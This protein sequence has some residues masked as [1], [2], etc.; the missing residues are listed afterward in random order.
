M[1]NKFQVPVVGGVRKV[2]NLKTIVDQITNIQQQLSNVVNA[3]NTI[4]TVQTAQAASPATNTATLVP[5]P[6][7]SGG[8]P[9]TG[10]V[11][12]R[13]N[14]PIPFIGGEEGEDGEPGPPG[15]A[16]PP[17]ATGPAGAAGSAGPTGGVGPAGPALFFLAED[18]PEGDFG[19]PGSAGPPGAT[20]PAG[21]AGSAGPTGGVGPAGPALFFLAEDGTDGTDGIPGAL[22]PALTTVNITPDTH[23][24]VVFPAND[25]FEYGS[26][27]DT[28]GLRFVGASRWVAIGNSTSTSVSQGMLYI[29]T[30]ASVSVAAY[31]GFSQQISNATW[32]YGAKIWYGGVAAANGQNYA[33]V[34]L[35]TTSG[36]NILMEFG[37]NASASTTIALSYRSTSD[38]DGTTLYE[39]TTALLAAQVL[40]SST[41]YGPLYVVVGYN[42]T[43]LY[44]QLSGVGQRGTF[45]NVYAEAPAAHLGSVPDYVGLGLRCNVSASTYIWCDWFRENI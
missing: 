28:A 36:A 42:G 18:G 12:I 30:S 23:P 31:G 26:T 33:L 14:A 25:E 38:G 21:A 34:N 37:V 39:T 16:G 35:T 1:T 4:N 9:I 40:A 44:W 10:P 7:L 8:G 5:G 24:S 15:S 3:V 41:V 45:S 29:F 22:A 27:I 17:G 43:D 11:S 19:P 32:E 20:G 2:I 6:G 13:L